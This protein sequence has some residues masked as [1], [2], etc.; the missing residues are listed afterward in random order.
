MAEA[1]VVALQ[2]LYFSLL[3]LG[4]TEVEING[5]DGMVAWGIRYRWLSDATLSARRLDAQ[6]QGVELLLTSHEERLQKVYEMRLDDA[7]NKPLADVLKEM[8]QRARWKASRL[9]RE[10]PVK[11]GER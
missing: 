5:V 2:E 11:N 4:W 9:N 3:R 10:L 6:R 7:A 8:G 1:S